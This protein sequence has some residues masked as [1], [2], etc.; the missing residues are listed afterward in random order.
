[1]LKKFLTINRRR[2]TFKVTLEKEAR[3]GIR[4]MSRGICLAD[5]SEARIRKGSAWFGQCSHVP[6]PGSLGLGNIRAIRNFKGLSEKFRS[7]MAMVPAFCE[8]ER[9]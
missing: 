1:M 3:T 4:A 5:S 8:E 7:F 6:F 2:P 9:L